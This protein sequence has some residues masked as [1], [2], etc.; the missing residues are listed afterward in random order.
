MSANNNASLV[1]IQRQ[2]IAINNAVLHNRKKII[3]FQQ[4]TNKEL[5]L[6]I[7]KQLRAI[8]FRV[9][10]NQQ[11]I[12]TKLVLSRKQYNKEVLKRILKQL[13]TINRNVLINQRMIE[14]LLACKKYSEEI[15][16]SLRIINKQLK[17]ISK[18]LLL[19]QRIVDNLIQPPI[20]SCPTGHICVP[21]RLIDGIG[22][23]LDVDPNE[24]SIKITV[25]VFGASVLSGTISLRNP[26][27][28][29]G[30]DFGIAVL[31]LSFRGEF[32]DIA[33]GHFRLILGG[34][35]CIGPPGLRSCT[36][37]NQII[38]DK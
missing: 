15:K 17:T 5:L 38:F 16:K 25:R 23:D 37:F 12:G 8:N 10:I 33:H 35:A 6:Q 9:L 36:D 2:L 4:T 32:G 26:T 24:P 34:R 31:E 14:R 19:S 22:L 1:R 13:Q 28:T 11:T 18:N 30:G 27:F 21:L 3:E 7:R 29:L 20:V